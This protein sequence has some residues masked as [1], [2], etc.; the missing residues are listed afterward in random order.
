MAG[1]GS[2]VGA[3]RYVTV[4]MS[5]LNETIELLRATLKRESFEKLMFRTFKEV[6]G[7]T[8]TIIGKE[9]AADYEVTQ[10]WVK[11]QVGSYKLNTGGEAGMSVTC[12]IP[13]KGHKGIVGGTFGAKGKKGS[14]VITAKVVKGQATT[15]PSI[16]KNQ[17]GNPPFMVRNSQ[18]IK[19]GLVFTR[20]TKN[21]L[22]IVRVVALAAPQMPMNR[23][24]EDVQDEIVSYIEKRL[25][26]N[27][28]YMLEKG[29]I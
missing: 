28:L 11:K 13:I 10:T 24:A 14:S 4:D 18:S 2:F 3:G 8:K 23:S 25:E 22:P 29:Q 1:R 17:G 26:H 6:G 9:A 27:F 21:R 19:N 20:R 12:T 7:K 16:M 5:E 15:L